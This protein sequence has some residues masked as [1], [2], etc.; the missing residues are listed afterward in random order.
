MRRV[1]VDSG[2]FFAAVVADDAAHEAFESVFA[3]A[4]HE[5][6]QLV[7]TN[8]VLYESHALLLNRARNGRHHAME[9]LR[10]A[11]SGFCL[12]ERVT[13]ADER[14]AFNLLEDHQDKDYS[15]TDVLSFV[16]IERLKI[17]EALA[18]DRHFRE[19]GRFVVLSG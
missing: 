11:R 3:R 4:V 7:T 16:V 10:R 6:W 19:Y 1:F 15:L 14:R 17:K 12:V 5:S 18:V 13:V 2:A 9:F 8:A